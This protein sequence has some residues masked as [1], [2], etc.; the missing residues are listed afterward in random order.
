MGEGGKIWVLACVGVGDEILG[1]TC[2]GE[3]LVGFGIVADGGIIKVADGRV[4]PTSDVG[5]GD[6]DAG[7]PGATEA[8]AGSKFVGDGCGSAVGVESWTGVAPNSAAACSV[9]GS[10]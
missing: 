9:G 6:E 10:G 2:A 1:W 5:F 8:V 4:A 3:A 7:A